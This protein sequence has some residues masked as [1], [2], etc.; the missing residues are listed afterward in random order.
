MSISA[1]LQHAVVLELAMPLVTTGHGN[2]VPGMIDQSVIVR[3]NDVSVGTVQISDCK[4]WGMSEKPRRSPALETFRSDHVIMGPDSGT[5][6][7][8]TLQGF[9][10]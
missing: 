4:G 6:H 9:E 3:A 10:A 2:L 7:L 5:Y 1:S 8:S